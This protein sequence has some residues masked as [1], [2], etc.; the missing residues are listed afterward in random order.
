MPV[1]VDKLIPNFLI[2]G[3][4]KSGTTTF[5]EDLAAHPESAMPDIKEPDILHKAVDA[6]HAIELWTQHFKRTQHGKVRG[7]GS[8]YYTMTP[9]FP[10]V[11]QLARE[12]MGKNGKIIYIVRDP[13]ERIVS[14]LAHDFAVGRITSTNFDDIALSERR[15]VDWSDY[16]TQI[17]PWIDA[18][19]ANQ[20]KI[21]RFEQFVQDRRRVVQDVSQFLGLDP[22]RLPVRHAISNKRGS[23]IA[24]KSP[25]LSK[26]VHTGIYREIVRSALPANVRKSL[27]HLLGRKNA[28]PN[29]TL[30]KNA[31]S[32]LSKRLFH[33]NS[34]INEINFL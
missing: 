26:L 4:C 34:W 15:Y 3:A 13:I 17:Q 28:P 6:N 27:R 21:V 29:V 7:E 12:V 11:S 22:D 31:R 2:V 25:Y 24:L 5:Y 33:V 32:N 23:Q 8:T 18:F 10:D 9:E 20:V 14:H 1:L 30:S 16:P 19:G